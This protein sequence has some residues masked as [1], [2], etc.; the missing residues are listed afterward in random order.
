MQDAH[1]FV[2][3]CTGRY[4]E[5]DLGFLQQ[6]FCVSCTIGGLFRCIKFRTVPRGRH[7]RTVKTNISTRETSATEVRVFGE[8][9]W[10]CELVIVFASGTGLNMTSEL[11]V[12]SI[13]FCI[14]ST[15]IFEVFSII[16]YWSRSTCQHC[17][18]RF[19]DFM[20]N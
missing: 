19:Q 2:R 7:S 14:F 4:L 5:Y 13:D 17:L 6:Q 11:L 16:C 18:I 20:G 10:S 9:L 15:L 3:C 1:T 8:A 12:E